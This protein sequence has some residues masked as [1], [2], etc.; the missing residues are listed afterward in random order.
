MSA[1]TIDR[2][3][4][5][6]RKNRKSRRPETLVFVDVES[7]LTPLD[8]KRDEHTFR[9]GWAC[10]AHY[11]PEPGLQVAE[12]FSFSDVL[13]FWFWLMSHNQEHEQIY[14]IGHNIAYDARLLRA[15]SILPANSYHPDYAIMAESCTF[16]SFKSGESQ[17][18]LL[19]NTN[20][21][22]VSLEVLGQEFGLPKSNVDFAT[23]TDEEL[24]TY[25]KRDVEILVKVW[26]FWLAFLDEHNLGDFAITS[27]SQAWNA[28]RHRFMDCQIGIH[29]RKDAIDLER[30]SY[31][32]GRTEVFR[33]GSFNSQP[34]Y[35]LDV[36]G[37]YAYCMATY[38]HPQKLLKIVKGRNPDELSRLMERWLAIA[39]VIV[40]TDEPLYPYRYQYQNS[41][42]VG[43]FRTQLTT[44]ELRLAL[45]K[46]HVRAI[47]QVALYEPADLFSDFIGTLTPLRQK[48]KQAG[49]VGRSLICKLLR[50][51][52]YGKFAQKGY[53][54][55]ILG[56]APL[57]K[58]AVR[59]WVHGETG[60]KCVDWTFGGKTIRQYY[61]G[62]SFDS[63][64]AISSHTTAYARVHMA[65]LIEL[66]GQE[67]VFYMDTD[68]LI[69][70]GD[71][72]ARL[73]LTI[74]AYKLGHLKVEGVSDHLEIYAKK[75]YIFGDKRTLKGIKSK[76]ERIDADTWLQTHFTTLN[77]AFRSG[78]LDNV[79]TYDVEKCLKHTVTTGI[80]HKDGTVAPLQLSLKQNQAYEIVKPESRYHW[81]WWVDVN[82]LASL[83]VPEESHSAAPPRLPW[84]LL[85]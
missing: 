18:H 52:L 51:G 57:D 43:V 49:D 11:E 55:E 14:I 24:E 10:L 32:G 5:W 60:E 78:N 65:S 50:N 80:V 22:Q 44:P 4:H 69:V 81:T 62:E 26:S 75:S 40:E 39:D 36:N 66:A 63:F 59:R 33:V 13:D 38:P 9:L 41:F 2:R 58:V 20:Y 6:L 29:N 64:P 79:T 35:K 16:F 19:D 74:D 61:K 28:Y 53:K 8:D 12:W 76:A 83:L 42:P 82:W 85:A 77:Y 48:Y 73:G 71:G 45:V 7:H 3:C 67:N 15:F 54:Q 21:W 37:L 34:Y 46:N 23:V 47:G 1:I 25:C 31:R 84:R 68:S 17:I 70:N 30:A 27:S 72:Y 56:D